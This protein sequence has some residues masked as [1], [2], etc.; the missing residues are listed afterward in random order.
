M[1]H[2]VIAVGPD[3]TFVQ[4]VECMQRRRV[5]ALPVVRDDRVVGIVSEADLL[6]KEA[7]RDRVLR[8]SESPH[9]MEQA[10]K[11]AGQRAEELMTAPAVCVGPD[12]PVTE[13]ARIMARE[14]L[15]RLP[16]TDE[17]GRPLG[18]VSRSDLLKVF[19]RRDEE[20]VEAVRREVMAE[21]VP[22]P[23]SALHVRVR[24]GVV[25]LSGHVEDTSVLPLVARLVGSVEGV[26][27]V[28]FDL[29]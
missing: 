12:A 17:V 6:S 3:A 25:T 10:V 19:L 2:P 13:A 11:A 5:G 28:Q 20:L 24:S 8:L 23:A 18:I 15:K 26:V 22:E 29:C 14:H 21:L 1:T 16:V 4:I 9:A 7:R 27:D